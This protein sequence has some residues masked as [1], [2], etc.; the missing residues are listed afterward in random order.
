MTIDKLKQY[1]AN[2]S[3]GLGRCLNNEPLYFRLIGMAA[4]DKSFA[5]LEEAL[6]SGDLDAAFNAAHTLKGA[7]GNLALTPMYRPVSE[8]TEL[9]RYKTPGDY[10]A[11]LNT[12]IEQRAALREII[13]D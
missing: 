1:G 4:E 9:L 8:L 3:E 13:K 12:I 5:Q 11:L 10:N 6:G 2:V 7:L